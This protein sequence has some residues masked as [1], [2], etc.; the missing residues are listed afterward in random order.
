M[1]ILA[2][3]ASTSSGTRIQVGDDDEDQIFDILGDMD[4]L[5]EVNRRE[6]EEDQRDDEQEIT[7]MSPKSK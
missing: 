3:E 6:D 4:W 7:A 1:L 5:D 2:T